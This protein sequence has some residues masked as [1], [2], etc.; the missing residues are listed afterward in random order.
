M[1]ALTVRDRQVR[2]KE[3][4]QGAAQAPLSVTGHRNSVF[5]AVRDAGLFDRPRVPDELIQQARH[6]AGEV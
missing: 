5:V 6:R 1:K 2:I 3:L 4:I